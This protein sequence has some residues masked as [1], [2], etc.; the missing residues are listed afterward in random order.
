MILARKRIGYGSED[1]ALTQALCLCLFLFV[2][3]AVGFAVA[4]DKIQWQFGHCL[5]I[6]ESIAMCP[7]TIPGKLR[8]AR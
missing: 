3:L 8:V 7:L 6:F 4:S 2:S 1:V 5:K